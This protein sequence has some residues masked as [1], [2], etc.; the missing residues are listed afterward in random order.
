MA[1]SSDLVGFV[2]AGLERGLPREELS[3]V[4]LRAGWPAD[5]VAR[6]IG[7][8][9][10]I[11]FVIPVPRPVAAGSTR[12]TFLY[13]VMFVTLVVSSYNFCSLVFEL[14][15][16]A[17]PDPAMVRQYYYR[18]TLQ[19]TRWDLA[20]LIVAFPVFLSIAS[21]M[22]RSVRREPIK[23][24]SRIRRQLTYVM[25]FLASN[26]LICDLIALIYN[27]L[28]GELSTRFVLKVL[29]V[30]LIAGGVFG[31]YLTDLRKDEKEPEA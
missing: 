1:L 10:D 8:F 28:G 2:K 23:R 25:L 24:A 21:F 26:A 6:A 15:N 22:E 17:F 3:T 27:F 12:D 11:P 30:G 18:S 13:L 19:E 7:G 9:A 31:Y 29:T 16:R 5:Q 14:I 20:S 4:L